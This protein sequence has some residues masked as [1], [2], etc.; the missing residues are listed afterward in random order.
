MPF[1]RTELD[2]ARREIAR[3][4]TEI[5]RLEHA[6]ANAHLLTALIS[7]PAVLADPDRPYLTPRETEVLMR[8]MEGDTNQAIAKRLFISEST[9]KTNLSRIFDKFQVHTRA[10]AVTAAGRRGFVKPEDP[11]R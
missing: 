7:I 10:G 11:E 6:L 5:Q 9:V 8:L 4:H 2:V 3:L 1:R